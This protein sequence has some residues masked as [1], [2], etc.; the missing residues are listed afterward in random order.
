MNSNESLQECKSTKKP[1]KIVVTGAFNSGK[2]H[3]IKTISGNN[4]LS[5]EKK[6]TELLDNKIS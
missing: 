2:T 6:A 5:T 3:F 1:I 4:M